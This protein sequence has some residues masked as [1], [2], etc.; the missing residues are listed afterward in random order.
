MAAVHDARGPAQDIANDTM[1]AAATA[2][3]LARPVGDGLSLPGFGPES[4]DQ[5]D[6]DDDDDDFEDD[7]DFDE[8]D[9]R[10]TV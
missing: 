1:G 8:D 9:W 10:R 3:R 4:L 7:E 5:D 2:G 6:D